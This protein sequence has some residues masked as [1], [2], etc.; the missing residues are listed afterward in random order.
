[1]GHK[2]K[3]GYEWN[4]DWFTHIIWLPQCQVSNPERYGFA[5]SLKSSPPCAAYLRQWT[6]SSLI[7]VM[8]CCLLGANPLP[9]PM[10][11]YS[12]LHHWERTSVKFELNYKTFH[13]WKC[14]WKHRL[15]NGDHFVQG[16]WVDSLPQQSRNHMHYT[17]D[18]QKHQSISLLA[19]PIDIL[20]IR[21]PSCPLLTVHTW[22]QMWP[23]S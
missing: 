15:R 20:L 8:A 6:R 22:A 17:Q 5:K 10:L 9:A 3:M 21:W 12:Q 1:M 2:A 23:R 4:Y 16:R 13:S 11:P 19:I 18:I 7:G 14:I